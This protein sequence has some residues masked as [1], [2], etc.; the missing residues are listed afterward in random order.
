LEIGNRDEA[1]AIRDQVEAA[2]SKLQRQA[3]LD[4]V[5]ELRDLIRQMAARADPPAA[6]P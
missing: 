2:Y 5:R 4:R 3:G 1:F 6:D